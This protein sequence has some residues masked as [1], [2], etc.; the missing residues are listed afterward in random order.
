MSISSMRAYF[1][2]FDETVLNVDLDSLSDVSSDL[3]FENSEGVEIFEDA[4]QESLKEG[5][6]FSK[7]FTDVKGL[8]ITDWIGEEDF[9]VQKDIFGRKTLVYSNS[10]SL[11]QT[12]YDD[13]MRLSKKTIW[14]LPKNKSSIADISL[15]VSYNYASDESTVADKISE[16]KVSSNEIIEY[17]YNAKGLCDKKILYT[18]LEDENKENINTKLKKASY[19]YKYDDENRLRREETTEYSE[20]GDITNVDKN[21]YVYTELCSLPDLYFYENDVLRM[22]TEYKSEDNYFVTTYFDG[23]YRV[24]VSYEHGRKVLERV[25]IKNKEIR[26]RKL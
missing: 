11:V 9:S 19:T 3:Q 16:Y 12:V 24:L 23:D 26:R 5:V 22:K 18:L 13:F 15:I 25:F 14:S 17:F 4:I 8:L 7:V 1:Y 6:D 10:D 20:N 2:P 21:V